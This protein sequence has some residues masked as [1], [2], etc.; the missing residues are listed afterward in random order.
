[1]RFKLYD[2]IKLYQNH[3]ADA[4]RCQGGPYEQEGID[5]VWQSPEGRQL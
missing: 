2:K 1:V 3:N 4:P 5:F